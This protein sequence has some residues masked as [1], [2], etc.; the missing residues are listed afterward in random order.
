MTLKKVFA[1]HFKLVFNDQGK[2]ACQCGHYI[3]NDGNIGKRHRKHA[4]Q[5]LEAH[6]QEREAEAVRAS[7]RYIERLYT[8]NGP[9]N[10]ADVLADLEIAADRLSRGLHAN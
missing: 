3:G 10:K 2:R 7:A 4:I 5:V 6:M 8:L 1:Q 9:I